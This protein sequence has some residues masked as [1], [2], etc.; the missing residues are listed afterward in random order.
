MK[1]GK[2]TVSIDGEDFTFEFEKS[3]A[4]KGAGKVGIDDD[5]LYLAGKLVKADKDNKYEI[6]HVQYAVDDA[7]EPTKE[8]VKVESME[9]AD[10]IRMH[11]EDKSSDKQKEDG[12]Q[13][14][15]VKDGVYGADQYYLINTS[16]KVIEKKSKAKDGD[17]YKITVGS[18][19][20][21]E[22]VLL[23]G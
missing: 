12:D 1:T 14:W 5:K 11:C 10:F 18:K 2:Q 16:G 9:T 4:R 7:G 15:E 8:I 17:D 19:Y 21:I 13:Y 6:Y 23:E 22:S 20:Q 3:G